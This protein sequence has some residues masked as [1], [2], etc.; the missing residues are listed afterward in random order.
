LGEPHLQNHKESEN[1]NLKK[2][3]AERRRD[4]MK[5]IILREPLLSAAKLNEF[6]RKQFGGML[7]TSTIYALKEELG[8]DRLGNLR[9]PNQEPVAR[10]RNADETN[11]GTFP[12]LIS[13]PDTD[14]PAETAGKLLKRLEESGVVNLRISGSGATWIVVEPAA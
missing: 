13:L 2:R 5:E 12:L 6:A 4:F 11:R 8:F 3:E 14:R 1:V 7:R 9:V 10:P